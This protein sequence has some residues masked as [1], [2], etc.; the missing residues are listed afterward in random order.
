MW[1]GRGIKFWGGGIV[2][3]DSQV[4]GIACRVLENHAEHVDAPGGFAPA[5]RASPHDDDILPVTRSGSSHRASVSHWETH[6]R[7]W[8]DYIV[9]GKFSPEW[10]LNFL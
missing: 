3:L 4:R 6:R 2:F 8:G 10:L 9:R 1:E 5:T 7:K